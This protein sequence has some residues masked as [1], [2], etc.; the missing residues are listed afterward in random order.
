LWNSFDLLKNWWEK[1]DERVEIE[2]SGKELET[3]S[4]LTVDCGGNV[5]DFP[6][7]A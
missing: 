2:T 4:I 6:M 5:S 7:E 3:W 1:C